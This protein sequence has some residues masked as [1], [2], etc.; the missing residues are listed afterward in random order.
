VAVRLFKELRQRCDVPVARR[1][2]DRVLRDEVRHRDF[3]WALLGWLLE[4]GGP[5]AAPL[6]AL[7]ARELPRFFARLRAVYA[8][9]G[10]A[11]RAALARDVSRWGLM[12]AA[13]YG[14][15]LSMT[16]ERD[17][18]PRF[19]RFGID[20]REAWGR[21]SAEPSVEPGPQ[22]APSAALR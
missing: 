1:V 9:A 15:V 16:L 18:V 12:P 19:A 4:P 10:A 17:Y 22:L 3:G 13:R 14:E 8:P 6:T 2:L 5:F 21:A 20:A 11:K 7:V